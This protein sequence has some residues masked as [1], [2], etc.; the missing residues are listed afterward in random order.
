MRD[1]KN[2]PIVE[3]CDEHLINTIAMLERAA[4]IKHSLCP[5][6]MWEGSCELDFHE[7]RSLKP[8]RE[9]IYR[10]ELLGITVPRPKEDRYEKSVPNTSL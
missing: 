2:I 4:A 3:M 8:L 9:E 5:G 7:S 6:C 1:G 10:R